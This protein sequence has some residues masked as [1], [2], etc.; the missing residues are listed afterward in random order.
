ML[1]QLKIQIIFIPGLTDSVL[2][3]SDK[4]IM[5]SLLEEKTSLPVTPVDFLPI[6]GTDYIE[7]YVGNAKQAAHFYKT[8]FGFQSLAY[9]GPETGVR[10]RA[11]YVLKQGKIRLVFTTAL[12]PQGDIA[13]HVFEHGDGVKVVALWVDDATSAFNETVKRG[14]RAYLN[15]VR[16]EDADGYVIRSGIY[17]YGETVHIFIERKNYHGAFLPG[18]V[19]Q[20][21]DFRPETTGLEYIDHVVGNVN[22]HQMNRWVNFY[23]TVM[24][25]HQLVSFDDADISTEYTAL[26]S[27]VMTNGNDRIKFPINEPAEGKKKSQIEEYL[28]YYRGEGVQHLA[29]A[30]ANIV[31]TVTKL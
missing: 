3:N 31:E 6:N 27:K 7:W 30:T 8:A 17:T 1:F 24:G 5:D 2:I 22:W 15:P 21:S 23:G 26:M 28:E 19:L 29:I 18:Y 11:S 13:C 10:D 16:E 12:L 20:E 25:F 14:A 9:A 4:K